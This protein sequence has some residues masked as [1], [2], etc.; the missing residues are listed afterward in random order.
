MCHNDNWYMTTLHNLHHYSVHRVS[1]ILTSN[2]L[3]VVIIKEVYT[4][5]MLWLQCIKCDV[6]V[7][8]VELCGA[9]WASTF[10]IRHPRNIPTHSC[11]VYIPPLQTQLHPEP[12]SNSQIILSPIPRIHIPLA[13]STPLVYCRAKIHGGVVILCMPTI[14]TITLYMLYII[15]LLLK[16]MH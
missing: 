15:I 5:S 14:Q 2:M 4:H 7:A 10:I 12:D 8:Q 13:L 3:C 16:Y 6:N 9:V 1:A 11:Y